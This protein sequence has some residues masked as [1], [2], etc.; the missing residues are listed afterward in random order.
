MCHIDIVR[1]SKCKYIGD[2]QNK[3]FE[4]IEVDYCDWK[5][6]YRH[7]ADKVYA[8]LFS[9]I[10]HV[11]IVEDDCPLCL[12]G[13]VSARPMMQSHGNSQLQGQNTYP[14]FDPHQDR[15]Q[16]QF[17]AQVHQHTQCKK[18]YLSRENYKDL[19]SSYN[20]ILEDEPAQFPDLRQEFTPEPETYSGLSKRPL[21]GKEKV[22]DLA[23][24]QKL[25]ARSR[26]HRRR[27]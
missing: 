4:T 13:E 14:H 7:D 21:Q 17:H 6:K 20:E 5:Y 27:L 1:Y 18:S 15:H 2:P 16:G 24:Q 11:E 22:R 3:H 19:D 10:R 26:G 8:P 9:T 23:Y 25:E 12:K